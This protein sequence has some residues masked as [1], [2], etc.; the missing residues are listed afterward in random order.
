MDAKTRYWTRNPNHPIPVDGSAS[1]YLGIP[2][3][4]EFEAWYESDFKGRGWVLPFLKYE[5]PGNPT[6]AGEPVSYGDYLSKVHDL[7]Y[8]YASF[9]KV[10]GRIN[11]EQFHERITFADEDFKKNQSNFTV[12]GILGQAGIGLKNFAEVAWSLL[13]GEEHIYPGEPNASDF[14]TGDEEDVEIVPLKDTTPPP[15]NRKEELTKKFNWSSDHYD[16]LEQYW[17][18]HDANREVLRKWSSDAYNAFKEFD[19]KYGADE[20]DNQNVYRSNNN[21]FN[22]NVFGVSKHGIPKSSAQWQ[23]GIHMVAGKKYKDDPEAEAKYIREQHEKLYQSLGND[24]WRHFSLNV[25]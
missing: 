10:K 2:Y 16:L 13:G 1:D 12:P 23:H 6:N 22:A 19:E 18:S 20:Q 15:P 21:E 17:R 9:L 25:N 14:L 4:A 11:K 8:A 3:D 5:G 7:R 24:Y